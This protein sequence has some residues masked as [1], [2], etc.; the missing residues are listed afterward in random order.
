MLSE[1]IKESLKK[2]WGEKANAL[3]CYAEVKFFDPLSDW[4][5]YIFGLNPNDEDEIACI[6]I[7]EQI[8]VGKWSLKELYLTYNR[9]GEHPIID[10]EYRRTRASEL[11][12]KLGNKYDT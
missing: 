9:E 5:C 10:Q 4:K 6:V 3:D 7:S 1:Q 11:L 8:E 12:N 2:N